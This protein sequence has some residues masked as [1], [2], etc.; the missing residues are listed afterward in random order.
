MENYKKKKEVYITPTLQS[1]FT[2]SMHLLYVIKKQEHKLCF[3]IQDIMNQNIRIG[4]RKLIFGTKL[5]FTP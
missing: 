1:E 5:N 2:T 4:E 3:N